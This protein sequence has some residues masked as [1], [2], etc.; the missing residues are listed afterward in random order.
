MTTKARMMKEEFNRA[1]PVLHL[2]LRYTVRT[3]E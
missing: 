3:S 1:D 2:L